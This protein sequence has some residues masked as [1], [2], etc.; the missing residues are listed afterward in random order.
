LLACGLSNGVIEIWDCVTWTSISTTQLSSASSALLWRISGMPGAPVALFTSAGE[1]HIYMLVPP[2]NAGS[3]GGSMPW[4][5][6]RLEAGQGDAGDGMAL[7]L[8][9]HNGLLCSGTNNGVVQIWD[10]MSYTISA[11]LRHDGAVYCLASCGSLLLAGTPEAVSVWSAGSDGMGDW[12]LLQSVEV[13]PE[14]TP[15]CMACSAPLPI[16]RNR[17]A[18]AVLV[19]CWDGTMQRWSLEEVEE[20]GGQT[21]QLR[22]GNEV[23]QAHTGAVNGVVLVQTHTTSLYGAMAPETGARTVGS[24]LVISG[25]DDGSVQAWTLM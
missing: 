9:W 3:F 21:V 15:T 17:R 22:L 4:E 1:S 2:A 18:V 23:A 14:Q 10:S 11:R 25:G 6:Q 12:V 8:A 19:G 5:V 7:T 20:Q 16:S 24:A 13:H